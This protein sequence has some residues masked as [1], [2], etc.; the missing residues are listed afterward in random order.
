M[1]SIH[2]KEFP[3]QSDSDKNRRDHVVEVAKLMMSAAHTA[4]ITGGVD[5]LETMKKRLNKQS[6]T[7]LIWEVS[8]V[9]SPFL[10]QLNK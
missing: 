9:A 8:L 7:S 6:G 2:S 5:H 1:P 4:P 10:K 3:W